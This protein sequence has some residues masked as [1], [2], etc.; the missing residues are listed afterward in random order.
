MLHRLRQLH[1]LDPHTGPLA[2]GGRQGGE[3]TR[4]T[5]VRRGGGA[6]NFYKLPHKYYC[7]VDLHSR[8]MY[9]CIVGQDG[10][11]PASPQP[12]LR[13]GPL[14]PRHRSLPRGPGRRRRVRLQLVLARRPLREGRH[15][16]RPRPRPL[17]AAHPRRQGQERPHR[18]REDR[19][20]PPG[21]PHARAPTPIPP[22]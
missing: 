6:M 15:R 21:R 20:A 7:G 12:P 11:G 4:R 3:Y 16:L 22:T 17:H 2:A 1:P 13:P 10:R 5:A 14:P 18:L 8:T 9:L 19:R